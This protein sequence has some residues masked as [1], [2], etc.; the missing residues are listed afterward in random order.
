MSLFRRRSIAGPTAAELIP[1]RGAQRA[2]GVTVTNETA[3]RHS[4]VWACLRLRA[5][6][7]S[8]MPVDVYRQVGEMKVE[9]PKPP[10]LVAPGGAGMG[11][12]EWLYSTQFD[13][14][15]AGNCFGLITA[16]DGLGL[17]ARIELVPL[18][19]VTVIVKDGVRKY[20]IY[21]KVYEESEVWH[22]RQY[23]MAGL[24]V[25]LS[26]IAYAAW[27]IGEYLSV[28]QFALDW[29]GNGAV[30]S[31]HLKNTAKTISP[32]DA[33]ETK[34]RFK[35]ATSSQDLFVTGNDWEYKMIQADAAGADWIEAKRYGIGDIARFFDCPGDLIDAAAN[36]SMTYANITQRNL[37]FLVMNLGPAIIR[38]ED[39]LSS[40]TSRPR[41]VKLNTDALL[42]MDPQA[43]AQMFA[44]QITSR[45]LAPSEARELEDRQ[46][47]T[48]QQLA[49]FDR[50]FGT[51]NP[52]PT[53]GASA[54]TG[55]TT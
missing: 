43:R 40:L 53:A 5:N 47:F 14:D 24:P 27:S 50:L 31:A 22:E 29:F 38:R 52:A 48:E 16:R 30:P 10:V 32:T 55:A 12:I 21:G 34:R 46:P 51:K 42:R 45:Q 28:Q 2:G 44:T 3:L 36:G 33:E 19:E 39:A 35:A 41:F 17:P 49:E 7:V 25:G 18:S 4:A 23:T 1:P 13:L 11:T 8:T 15:R 26:P 20:R 37:Q 6:L 9:V 54:P